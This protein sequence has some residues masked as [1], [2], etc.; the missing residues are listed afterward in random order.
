MSGA[1]DRLGLLDDYVSGAMSD[2][3][4]SPF[5][6]A[7]FEAAADGTGGEAAFLDEAARLLTV[8]AGLG[9]FATGG[10]RQHVE[11]IR[12]SG[13][14]VHYVELDA[15]AGGGSLSFPLWGDGIDVVVARLGVDIRGY[16]LVDVEIETGDG[17]PVKTFR[18]VECDPADGAL[19]AICQER[20][21]RLAFA[22]GRSISRIVSKKDGRRE[23][24]ALFDI[25][26][27]G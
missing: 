20:L 7:L 22:R 2:G 24:I 25:S 13:A 1:A 21:A 11:A 10:T 5:E 26:P 15:P 23:T 9:G 12:A 3:D 16:G 14:K 4:A 6:A 27:V 17:R 8:F 19:Y 18:D